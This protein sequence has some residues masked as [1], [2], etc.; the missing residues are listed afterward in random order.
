[1]DRVVPVAV[2]AMPLEAYRRQLRIG[3]GDATRVLAAVEFRPNAKSGP[4]VRRANAHDRG[5]VDWGPGQCTRSRSPAHPA[6]PKGHEV[7]PSIGSNA[8]APS[9]NRRRARCP[10]NPLIERLGLSIAGRLMS[11]QRWIDRTAK[12]T[13]RTHRVLRAAD[14]TCHTNGERGRWP[15]RSR[16]PSTTLRRLAGARCGPRS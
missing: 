8:A 10:A 14:R 7:S 4:T 2:K 9:T 12:L 11:H 13:I 16:G 3:D 15:S 5:Q 1:M 6:P